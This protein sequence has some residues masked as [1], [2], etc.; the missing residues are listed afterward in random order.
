MGIEN[1]RRMGR[2]RRRMMMIMMMM[3]NIISLS[4]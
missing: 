4:P 1:V 3:M 2:R